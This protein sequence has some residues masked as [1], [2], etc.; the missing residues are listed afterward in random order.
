MSAP[1]PSSERIELAVDESSAGLRLDS[2]LARQFPSYSRVRLR[3]IIN[4]AGVT[5]DGRRV[6]ASYHLRCG[7]R[8]S[9][10]L[11]DI[12]RDGPEPE[13]IPLD[14]VYEDEYL[15][16]INKPAGMVVHPAKGHWSGTLASALAYHFEQLSTL[17]G[18]TRP[19]IVHRLDRDS[20][21]VIVVAKDDA[22]HSNLARQFEERRVAKQYFAIVV[23]VPDRDRDWIEEPIGRHPKE[24]EKMAIRRH[25][26]S[27][28]PAA[29]FYEVIERFDGFATVVISPRTGRTHQIRVHLSSIGCPVLCD[30]H[31][32]G[33]RQITTGEIRR[34]DDPQVLLDRQALHAQRIGF[35]HPETGQAVSFEVP[36]PD[37]I[38]R[39]LAEL[40]RYRAL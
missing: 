1:E 9:I 22:A 6:K 3:R 31:Y 26:A 12:P 29:S 35:T 37:D 33:R 10:T 4:A 32:G 19:G 25:D 2:Y 27:S 17:G 24:R 23:G 21:G 20:S 14:I 40:R 30:R 38:E 5:V 7:E 16:V 39:A 34:N 36:L 18:P 28:R 8:V 13:P 15:A 11:P